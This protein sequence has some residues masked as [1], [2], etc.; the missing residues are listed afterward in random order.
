MTTLVNAQ[1]L[2]GFSRA[3]LYKQG[4]L[5][6]AALRLQPG[7]WGMWTT[8]R[9]DMTGRTAVGRAGSFNPEEQRSSRFRS[10]GPPLREER[11]RSF[12]S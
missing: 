4:T 7:E 3:R 6:P 5:I 12:R 2:Q 10:Y 9:K 8:D 11:L 1:R